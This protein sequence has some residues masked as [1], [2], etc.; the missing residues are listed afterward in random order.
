ME[1]YNFGIAASEMD[2]KVNFQK[3]KENKTFCFRWGSFKKVHDIN[4]K[5]C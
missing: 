3:A 1:K 2:L 5:F 4:T